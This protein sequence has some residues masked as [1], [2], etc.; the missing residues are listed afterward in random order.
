VAG[1]L[2]YALPG[3]HAPLH[4][5][6]GEGPGRLCGHQTAVPTRDRPPPLP[7][8]SVGFITAVFHPQLQGD[9]FTPTVHMLRR[10]SAFWH[11]TQRWCTNCFTCTPTNFLAIEACLPPLDLLFAYKRRLVNLRILYSLP[12]INQVTVRLPPSVQTASLHCHAPDH[13][14]LLRGNAG[15]CLPLPWL[16]PRPSMRTGRTCLWMLSPILSCFC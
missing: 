14:I 1:I 5:A 7:M 2:A 6:S 15:S 8:Q 10:L 11:K 13:R 4:Q 9:V 16:Q 3:H 12:E